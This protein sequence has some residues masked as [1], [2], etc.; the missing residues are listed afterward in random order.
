[1]RER[2]EESERFGAAQVLTLVRRA[3]RYVRPFRFQFGV[4]LLFLLLS[5]IPLLFL[6][7]PTRVLID[8]VIKGAPLGE[9][10]TPFPFFVQPFIDAASGL[11]P[12]GL[13]VWTLAAQFLLLLLIGAFGL[14]LRERDR[15]DHRGMSQGWD[16]ATRTEND[17]NSGFSEIG[18][19]LGLIDYRWTMRLTQALNHHYRS[20]L[21]DRIQSLPMTSLDDERIGDAV[22]RVMYDTTVITSTCYK[23][24]LTPIGSPIH[25]AMTVWVMGLVYG[26][27]S[28]LIWAG[29]GF[30]GVAFIPTLPFAGLHRR[31]AGR[32]RK[33]GATT[34]SSIEE[35]MHNVLAVQ[36]LGGE[37]RERKRFDR[38]SA[39]SFRQFRRFILVDLFTFSSAAIVGTLLVVYVFL[40]IGDGIIDGRLSTGD[41]AV[42]MSFFVGIAIS[43]VNLGAIW[44]RLQ[45]EAT[46]LNRVFFLMDAPSE[47]DI[48]GSRELAPIE[49]SIE[50]RD[51]HFAYEPETPTLRGVSF[52]ARVGQ[53]VAFAGAAGA[54]KSTLAYLIPRF[55]EPDQ[56]QVLADGEDIAE[57]RLDSL[58][59]QI[60][61]VF[62]ET[63]LFDATIADNIRL[64]NPEASDVEMRRAAQIAGAADFIEALP[65]GYETRL[66]RGGG[67]L[68]VGQ[69]Q[70]L[71]IARALVRDAPILILDEPTSA[72]DPDTE[73]RLVAALREA[74]RTRIVIVIAH[75]LSTIREA[76]Q[77]LFLDG[78]QIVERGAHRELMA[79][80]GGAYRHYVEI[81]TGEAA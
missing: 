23:I 35:S 60:A 7:W 61:F 64:G 1:M 30:I 25:I 42:L 14:D 81:Q 43:S 52:E 50:V 58:R 9:E 12:T 40:Y 51:V 77:I 59:S 41:F 79:R 73:R 56:G 57:A 2:L 66:G 80:P 39:D 71:S 78:G 5:F 55:V 24:I 45:N 3:L 54:G 49:R 63:V 37:A 33:A 68:S 75:R 13:L 46:G 53:V 18:G 19:L 48:D 10:I 36:S 4:K 32:S 8:H 65:E 76:D 15:A 62:Q 28:P 22:Y 67:K 31:F 44:I 29:L 38:D 11:S 16:T 70:R 17:A 34:T 47:R 20:Q 69:K 26:W 74:S 21:F 6:P 72:L 27:Q